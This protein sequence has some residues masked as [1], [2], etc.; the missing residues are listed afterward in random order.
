MSDA[1]E[2]LVDADSRIQERMEELERERARVT[3]RDE[4]D[5]AR[6]H[7]V[8]SLKLART[9]L[10]RQ[11]AAATHDRHRLQLTQAI[12]EVDRRMA[13]ALAGQG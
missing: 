1:G 5:P 3:R 10:E 13:A 6:Q 7:A 8:E 9:A 12:E 4:R 2:G 11:R